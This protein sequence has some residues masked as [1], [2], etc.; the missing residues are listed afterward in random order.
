MARRRLD[1]RGPCVIG[2]DVTAEVTAFEV[3]VE[4]KE[5]PLTEKAL[6][7]EKEAEPGLVIGVDSD[8]DDRDEVP[9]LQDDALPYT[10]AVRDDLVEVVVKEVVAAERVVTGTVK[11]KVHQDV[12]TGDFPFG[13]S[14]GLRLLLCEVASLRSTTLW[15]SPALAC[16]RRLAVPLRGA[17]PPAPRLRRGAHNCPGPEGRGGPRRR[18]VA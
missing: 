12:S 3:D 1:A 2:N 10:V 7:E 11:I 14:K 4:S 17:T 6:D 16:S 5:G 9:D 13:I 15:R 18:S 8:D